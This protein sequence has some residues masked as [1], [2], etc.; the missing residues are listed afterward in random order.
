MRLGRSPIQRFPA[1][2][3]SYVLMSWCGLVCGGF[4]LPAEATCRLC[5]RSLRRAIDLDPT[6]SEPGPTLRRKEGLA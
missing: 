2:H 6:A 4:V 3:T 1:H 5:H